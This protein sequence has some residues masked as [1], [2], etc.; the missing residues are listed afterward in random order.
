MTAK[1][2]CVFYLDQKNVEQPL[3]EYGIFKV[4]PSE[5]KAEIALKK[6]KVDINNTLFPVKKPEE[7]LPTSPEYIKS[8]LIQKLKTLFVKEIKIV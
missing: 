7:C 8:G 1:M 4:F 5:N 6:A 2:Y 3:C